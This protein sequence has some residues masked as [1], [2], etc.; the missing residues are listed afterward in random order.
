MPNEKREAFAACVARIKRHK[1]KCDYNEPEMESILWASEQLEEAERKLCRAREQSEEFIR[2]FGKD[3]VISV[4][5]FS[6]PCRH[7]SALAEL[8]GF[9]DERLSR[10]VSDQRGA[11][12]DVRD[13]LLGK[14]LP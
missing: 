5:Q 4:T 9:L 3:N 12:Q 11:Y 1:E 7:E 6:S 8:R 2:R 14:E 10:C 13:H